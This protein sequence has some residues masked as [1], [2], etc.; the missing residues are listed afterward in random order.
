ML[1]VVARIQAKLAVMSVTRTLR[2]WIGV[3]VVGLIGL[4]K[5]G[6]VEIGMER[7]YVIHELGRPTYSLAKGDSEVLTYPGGVKI[8]LTKGR[9]S[10]IGGLK[11]KAGATLSK[12]ATTAA[13]APAAEAVPEEP[14]VTKAQMDE[15][16]KL[17][18]EEAEANAKA[19]AKMEKAI[20][21]M[22]NS[23]D[24][25][26]TH[27]A[28]KFNLKEFVA[29]LVLKWLLTLAALKLTFKYWGADIFLTGLLLVAAVDVVIRAAMGAIGMMWLQMPSLFYADEAIAAIVMVMVLRKVSI[30]QS[31]GQAVQ[32]TMTTKTFSI[33]VGSFLFT[34]LLRA[35]N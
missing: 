1:L 31:L 22:E 19:R 21:D 29:G 27:E 20:E 30:N 24:H 14:A 23:H 9:V 11:P 18:H 28:P 8:T 35:I 34:I 15:M 12:P 3:I 32:I 4:T 33:V 13:S 17:E 26:A 10:D 2:C 7:I 6:A 5:I 16:A 25:P